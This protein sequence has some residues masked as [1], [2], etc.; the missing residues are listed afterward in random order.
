[1]A[2]GCLKGVSMKR[3]KLWVI[4]IMIGICLFVMV[5]DSTIITTSTDIWKVING[6]TIVQ[7]N[8]VLNVN[9]GKNASTTYKLNVNGNTNLNGTSHFRG[10]TFFN[11][12]HN[13]FDHDTYFDGNVLF[14]GSITEFDYDVEFM[15]DV[16]FY[17][18]VEF[19]RN[20]TY[21]G[22]PMGFVPK[23]SIMIWGGSSTC[24]DNSGW[25]NNATG[26]HLCN[27]KNGAVDLTGR[28]ILGADVS[29]TN[30]IYHI[31]NK[32]G[33][34]TKT[35]STTNLP[36]HTHPLNGV[37]GVIKSISTTTQGVTIGIPT[38]IKTI[39]TTTSAAT[40]ATGSGTPFNILP[41]YYCLAYIQFL[42]Y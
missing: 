22:K 1:M 18:D 11:G 35:L 32:S 2:S 20:V 25:L 41:P 9:I 21:D 6:D 39:S 31:Y 27:G 29:L 19:G 23:G 17:G 26:W 16:A 10:D 8:T 28:F 5:A 3:N 40:D 15:S 34:T 7:N 42:G 30:T 36:S 38:V 13:T 24:F 4:P 37:I 33:N 14:H 12:L